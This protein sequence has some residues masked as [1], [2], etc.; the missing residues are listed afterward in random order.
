MKLLAQDLGP[1]PVKFSELDTVISKVISL[2]LGF[3]GIALFVMLV[4]GGYKFLT[5]GGDPKKV[6]G[7]K[8]TLTLA[9]GGFVLLLLSFFIILFIQNITGAQLTNFTVIGK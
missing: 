9:I 1:D 4:L 6:E 2:A 7:A 8:S 5:S 3:A